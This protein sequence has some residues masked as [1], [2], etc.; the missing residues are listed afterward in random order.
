MKKQQITSSEV[1]QLN[2][3]QADDNE[4]EMTGVTETKQKRK[5]LITFKPF[6]KQYILDNSKIR[7]ISSNT[8]NKKVLATGTY[9][10]DI[11][12]IIDDSDNEILSLN[13]FCLKYLTSLPSCNAYNYSEILYNED[14]MLIYDYRKIMIA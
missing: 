7:V 12:N 4:S 13:E 2:T 8:K 5:T 9:K 11:N 10:K 14:W 3:T 1:K 6:A